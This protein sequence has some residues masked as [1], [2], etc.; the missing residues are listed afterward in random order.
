MPPKKAASGPSGIR[1]GLLRTPR[2][3]MRALP[4]RLNTTGNKRPN[5]RGTGTGSAGEANSARSLLH[6]AGR[7]EFLKPDQTGRQ[8]LLDRIARR[9][10]QNSSVHPDP[11]LQ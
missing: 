8:P 7:K 2:Q 5:S 6:R 10:L 9:S 4:G 1:R 11:V 3:P